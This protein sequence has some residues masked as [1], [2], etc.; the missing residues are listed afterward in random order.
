MNSNTPSRFYK[1]VKH[2]VQLHMVGP[3]FLFT[4]RLLRAVKRLESQR[5]RP[6]LPAPTQSLSIHPSPAYINIVP[7]SISAYSAPSLCLIT[8]K[9]PSSSSQLPLASSCFH[10]AMPVFRQI[11]F[12]TTPSSR[13]QRLFSS[14]FPN[15]T[16]KQRPELPS[17]CRAKN[18]GL[19]SP[20]WSSSNPRKPIRNCPDLTPKNPKLIPSI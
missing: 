5:L 14:P 12:R 19:N 4:A 17:S 18:T 20:P 3:L 8:T 9:W 7:R 2:L 11:R 10:S 15:M 6:K 1:K 13:S 16:P